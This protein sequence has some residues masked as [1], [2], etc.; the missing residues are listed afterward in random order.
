MKRNHLFIK[1]VAAI[2]LVIIVL[3][4]T[5]RL[6]NKAPSKELSASLQ[7]K[8]I[9]DDGGCLAC[10]NDP[11]KFPWYAKLPVVKNMLASDAANALKQINL[12]EAYTTLAT[13]SP[14]GQVALNKIENAVTHQTMPPARFSVMH[15]KS[16]ITKAKRES[17]LSW[18][19]G[20]RL[21]FYNNGLA[22]EEFR[23]EPVQ[24][25]QDSIPVD[26]RKV[27]LGEMLFH[28]VRLS[29]DN[30]LSCASCHDLTTAGMDNEI[31]SDGVG[32]AVGQINSPTVYNSVYNFVQFWDGRANTLAEQAAGP[33]LNPIEMA[34]KSFDQIIEK[35][36]QDKAFTK[37]FLEVYPEMSEST[38]TDAI[39]EFEKTLLTP[40]SRFDKYLK[41]DLTALSAQ[42][43]SGYELFKSHECATC[44]SGVTLG[45]QSYEYLGLAQDYFAE[46]GTEI[47]EED[48]GRFKQTG[49]QYDMH[50]FKV[51]G[52]RNI[53]LT[54]P[55][56][57]DGTQKS[58]EDAVSAMLKYQLGITVP[59][60]E[61]GDIVA[62]LKTLTGEYKGI[63]LTNGTTSSTRK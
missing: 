25:I 18:A 20:H 43:I 42:E 56:F 14:M 48:G 23:N 6:V 28:D 60:N 26:V 38:I 33:P 30:T 53:A 2:L 63:P 17:L 13:N 8:A 1:I 50:R 12:S 55:Y 10:H 62:F 54:E 32:G 3:F 7:T 11:P 59:D 34:S 58:L 41:G 44:H 15:W 22:A 47:T 49:K 61:I 51:P 4:I 39:G 24:P 27:I 57:H 36:R 37:A 40:N 21:T 29:L 31:V 45:G 16:K 9:I 52:L 35:L 5:A 46:R 19:K